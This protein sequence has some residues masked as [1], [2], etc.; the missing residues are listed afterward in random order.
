VPFKVSHSH[1]AEGLRKLIQEP[2]LT[3]AGLA[4]DPYHLP[5]AGLALG[6]QRLQ[7]RQLAGASDERAQEAS[8]SSWYP[9]A[10]YQD[11][12]HFVDW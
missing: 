12:T 10:P 7:G 8:A 4:D 1:V 6:Q 11:R 9:C 2:R 3:D 5:L